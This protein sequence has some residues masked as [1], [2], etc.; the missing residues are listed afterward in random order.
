MKSPEKA[1]QACL[2]LC[3]LSI[4]I[5]CLLAMLSQQYSARLLQLE[6]LAFLPLNWLPVLNSLV[7]TLTIREYRVGALRLLVRKKKKQS[8][9]KVLQIGSKPKE[10]ENKRFFTNRQ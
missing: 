8:S 3:C 7:A 5:F 2:P 1:L 10:M 6:L 4:C 9:D